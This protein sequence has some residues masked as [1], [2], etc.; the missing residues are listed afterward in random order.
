MFPP[1]PTDTS[2]NDLDGRSLKLL[3]D[4]TNESST[5]TDSQIDGISRDRNDSAST[6]SD[7]YERIPTPDSSW[8]DTDTVFVEENGGDVAAEERLNAAVGFCI[9]DHG[10]R[11]ASNDLLCNGCPYGQI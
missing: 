6:S 9:S 1:L 7:Q 3:K 2:D 8:S 10:P 5:S 11:T 4:A